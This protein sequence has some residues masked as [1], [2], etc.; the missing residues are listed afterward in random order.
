[1]P[2]FQ[3]THR[4]KSAN[5]A[6]A[7]QLSESNALSPCG[8]REP[9]AKVQLSY[10]RTWFRF[11]LSGNLYSIPNP[12]GKCKYFLPKIFMPRQE[13]LFCGFRGQRAACRRRDV[14]NGFACGVAPSPAG[15]PFPRLQTARRRG[16][17]LMHYPPGGRHFPSPVNCCGSNSAAP[18]SPRHRGCSPP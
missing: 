8:G 9:S 4:Q 2:D 6:I 11:P 3:T 1:M 13:S 17:S 14:A 18:Q 10:D 12:N 7:S 16:P 15:V 5:H